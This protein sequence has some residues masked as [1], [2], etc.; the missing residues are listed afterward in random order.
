VLSNDTNAGK[1]WLSCQL[2]QLAAKEGFRFLPYKP[3]STGDRSDVQRLATASGCSIELD[4]INPVHFRAP[5]APAVASHLEK[6]QIDWNL[7]DECLFFLSKISDAV[8]IET[9]GGVL[10]PCDA[11]TDMIDLVTRWQAQAIVIIPNK[12]GTITQTRCVIEVLKSRN[13][14]PLAV[15]LNDIPEDFQKYSEEETPFLETIQKWNLETLRSYFPAVP[16]FFSN[17][18]GLLDLWSRIRPHLASI[19]SRCSD[20]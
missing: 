8:L 5:L 20:K 15:M 6:K 2:L 11:S 14:L 4:R 13:I 19:S 1:T 3:I 12:L 10:T 17:S 7:V 18:S 16:L 9:A